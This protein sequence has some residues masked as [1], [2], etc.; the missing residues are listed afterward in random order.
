MRIQLLQQCVCPPWIVAL[1]DSSNFS[2]PRRI[3]K[4]EVDFS[5]AVPT[6][7]IVWFEA[8]GLLEG[9]PR[10]QEGVILAGQIQS[11][12]P[13]RQAGR[14]TLLGHGRQQSLANFPADP[15]PLVSASPS[16]CQAR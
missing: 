5:Q 9:Q 4:E 3:A 14:K 10:L 13:R 15:P 6:G 12:A 8:Q 16:C 11:A 1:Q 2:H 7:R